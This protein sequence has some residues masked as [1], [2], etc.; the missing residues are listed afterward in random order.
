MPIVFN[1]AVAFPDPYL[2]KSTF[3]VE[4]TAGEI[5]GYYLGL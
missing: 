5:F 3:L 4:R 1:V 2:P